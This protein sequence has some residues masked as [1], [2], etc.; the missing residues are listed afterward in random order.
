MDKIFGGVTTTPISFNAINKNITDQSYN[1]ESE[2]A[3]SGKAVAEAIRETAS[4]IKNTLKGEALTAHDVSPVEHS[5]KVSVE[6]KNIIGEFKADTSTGYDIVSVTTDNNGVVHFN[7]TDNPYDTVQTDSPTTVGYY[8]GKT[9][10]ITNFS[11]AENSQLKSVLYGYVDDGNLTEF[12]LDP[13][14]IGAHTSSL[15][16]NRAHLSASIQT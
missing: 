2:N 3:Q 16:R 8:E 9:I 4:A 14:D 12:S 5:L 11:V 6:S 7:F 13:N 1:P 10:T 15:I